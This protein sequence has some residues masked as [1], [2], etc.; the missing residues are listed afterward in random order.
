MSPRPPTGAPALD[1][2]GGL[3]APDP[4]ISPT[5][6][7]PPSTAND[8]E[9]SWFHPN[10][11][12]VS[13]VIAERYSFQLNNEQKIKLASETIV[14]VK[15][16]VGLHWVCNR[17][18]EVLVSLCLLSSILHCWD[19]DYESNGIWK[20][21][22]TWDEVLQDNFE[23]VLERQSHQQDG[24]VTAG[25]TESNGSLPPGGWLMVTCGLTACTPG[26]VPDPTLSNKY[27]KPLPFFTFHT[28]FLVQLYNSLTSMQQMEW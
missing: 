7:K 24:K 11:F 17:N 10:R 18:R 6:S 20:T 27:G 26:S 5:H 1:P 12:T 8:S 13:G 9:C 3:P 2:A 15:D 19:T 14:N 21:L 22:G 4:L 16:I 25:L 23:R 28:Q